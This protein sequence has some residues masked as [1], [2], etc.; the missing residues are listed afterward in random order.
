MSHLTTATEPWLADH[1]VDGMVVLP[2]AAMIEM[3]LAAAR[4]R[5]P[6]AATL[7]LHDLEI[8]RSL[9]LEPGSVLDC[10]VSVGAEGHLE[11]ASRPR[12][13]SEAPTRHATCRILPG[14]GAAP[15]LAVSAGA[16]PGEEIA[17]DAV[18]AAAASVRLQYGPA[19]GPS[20]GCAGWEP[21][22]P[23]LSWPRRHRSGGS[24]L[25]PGPDPR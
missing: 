9:V 19:F 23:W 8:T 1:V 15:L 7:E 12:L 24:R 10:R 16:H 20:R 3:A 14:L 21:A 18:Y 22:T 25:S 4:S 5:H 17:A 11:L 6:E 13:A 2:A